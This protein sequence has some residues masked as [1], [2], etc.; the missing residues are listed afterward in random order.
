MAHDETIERRVAGV[1][2]RWKN[3]GRKKMF[4]GVCHLLNGK[5][6]AGVLNDALI[7]RLGEK[8]AAEALRSPHVRP[9]D[10]PGRPMKGWV[11]VSPEGFPTDGELE[12]W[13]EE[14]RDFVRTLPRICPV[15]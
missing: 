12:A 5:V 15:P 3:T 6:A 9:F 13:L 2:A 7:P 1:V 8:G 14:A 11:M 4:G 10:I